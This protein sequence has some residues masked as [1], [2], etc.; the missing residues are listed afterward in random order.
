V[1][2]RDVHPQWT[3]AEEVAGPD[4]QRIVIDKVVRPEVV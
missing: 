3:H 2:Q 1:Q 4:Q